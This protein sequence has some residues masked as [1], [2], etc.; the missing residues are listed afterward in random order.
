M[1]IYSCGSLYLADS[2]GFMHFHFPSFLLG[3][4]F[5][6]VLLVLLIYWLLRSSV[7]DDERL[8]SRQRLLMD[9]YPGE[10]HS[11]K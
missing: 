11:L 4:L 2:R 6:I 7:K 5:G 1:A 8:F 10:D 3:L 9:S